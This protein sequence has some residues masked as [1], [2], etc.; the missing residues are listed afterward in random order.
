MCTEA[1]A[2]EPTSRRSA[3]SRTY[4][5]KNCCLVGGLVRCRRRRSCAIAQSRMKLSLEADWR[6]SSVCPPKAKATRSNR[7]GCASFS[8][9]YSAICALRLKL[10]ICLVRMSKQKN[11]SGGK[12]SPSSDSA[13]GSQLFLRRLTPTSLRGSCCCSAASASFKSRTWRQSPSQRGPALLC[14]C[15]APPSASPERFSR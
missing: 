9:L 14:V 13:I 11:K 12:S 1:D 8:L 2:H 3:R 5:G 10:Q 6:R 15:M 7:V 4:R